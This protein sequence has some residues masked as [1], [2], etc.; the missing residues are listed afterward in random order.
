MP[1]DTRNRPYPS[2]HAPAAGSDGD[3]AASRLERHAL[4]QHPLD[5]AALDGAA[6]GVLPFWATSRFSIAQMNGFVGSTAP[7]NLFARRR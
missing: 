1:N 7:L 4:D 2:T 6:G 5:E 3:P